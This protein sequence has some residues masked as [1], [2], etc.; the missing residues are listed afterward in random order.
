MVGVDLMNRYQ[1]LH[2]DME[3]LKEW[4]KN[5]V[6]MREAF[7]HTSAQLLF[8][9]KQLISELNH[10]YPIVQANNRH[11]ICGV[12][13]PNSEDF[14]GHDE[15]MISIALGFVAH[16]VQMISIFLQLPLRY[17]VNHFGS[18][19]KIVDHIAEKI[20]DKDRE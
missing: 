4:K 18:R 5:F 11:T 16:L 10:I 9:R 2:K 7:L 14:A 20:P 1:N 6:E 19:S 3:H 8:R 17:P 12:H 15:V 13:L